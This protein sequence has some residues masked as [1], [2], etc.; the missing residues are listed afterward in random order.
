MKIDLKCAAFYGEWCSE[1][2]KDFEILSWLEKS[3]M[4][5]FSTSKLIDEFGYKDCSEIKTSGW[6]IP[7]FKTDTVALK[8]EFVEKF[9]SKEVEC[10]IQKIIEHNNK[11][12]DLSGYDV[13]FRIYCEEHRV[14]GDNYWDYERSTLFKNAVK[15]CKENNIPY[16]MPND[17]ER[18]LNLNDTILFGYGGEVD[19]RDGG[20]KEFDFWFYKKEFKFMDPSD[21]G[22]NFGYKTDDEIIAS[23]DF[24]LFPRINSDV[25]ETQLLNYAEKWA[26]KNNIPYY[27]PQNRPNHL[28]SLLTDKR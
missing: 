13:A 11:H 15:W 16:Y 2:E 7:V 22:I 26:I 24:V 6:F 28:G 10:E 14:F 20:W 9:Y 5:F 19:D 12:I 8:K 23:G 27:I 4:Q 25:E 1:Y 21:I 18:K 17:P 3:S